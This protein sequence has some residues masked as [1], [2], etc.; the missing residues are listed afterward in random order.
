AGDVAVAGQG[1]AALLYATERGRAGVLAVLDALRDENWAAEVVCGEGLAAFGLAPE[2]GLLAAVDMA[3]Q[4][5]TNAHG[6]RGRR[7][8][9]A[10]PD[11]PAAIGSG[12]HGGR[13]PGETRP[14]LMLNGTNVAPGVLE[15]ATS[16]VDIAPTLLAFLGLPRDG[17][18]GVS[19]LDRARSRPPS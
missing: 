11:K 14:F 8:V 12:Q 17:F 6:V 4:D 15:R 7:W 19:L 13:G 2:G 5:A 18:D 16:L 3:R 1:T 10:E 9:V